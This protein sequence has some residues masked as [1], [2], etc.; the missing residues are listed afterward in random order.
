MKLKQS[1]FSQTKFAFGMAGDGQRY[2]LINCIA[3]F[4]ELY[5]FKKI[6]KNIIQFVHTDDENQYTCTVDIGR[7]KAGA[8]FAKLIVTE[9]KRLK[10]YTPGFNIEYCYHQKYPIGHCFDLLAW[11]RVDVAM[12]KHLRKITQ[13]KKETN[14]LHEIYGLGQRDVRKVL[15]T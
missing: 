15:D 10:H 13:Y 14:A 7:L 2:Q 5:K 1:K 6:A 8:L 11:M 12:M 9:C 3:F 4:F